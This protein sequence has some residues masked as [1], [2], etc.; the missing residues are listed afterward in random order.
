MRFFEGLLCHSQFLSHK[1]AKSRNF[2]SLKHIKDQNYTI[3]YLFLNF[4]LAKGEAPAPLAPPWLR[5]C[6]WYLNVPLFERTH[7]MVKFYLIKIRSRVVS[8]WVLQGV[9]TKVW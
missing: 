7:G 9:R 1:L 4:D 2:R 6:M 5:P 8:R 3:F